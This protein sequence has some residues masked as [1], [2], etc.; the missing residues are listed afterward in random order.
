MSCNCVHMY[1]LGNL[2]ACKFHATDNTI[3]MKNYSIHF[4][5]T[6]CPHPKTPGNHS[7][8]LHCY[9]FV[10]IRECYISGIKY[11][12]TLDISFILFPSQPVSFEIHPS[13]HGYLKFLPLCCQVASGVVYRLGLLKLKLLWTF[14]DKFFCEHYFYFLHFLH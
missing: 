8:V 14:I 2:I 7:S 9:N 4:E 3:R 5:I 13:C 12:V 6:T 10:S 11:Y 1:F